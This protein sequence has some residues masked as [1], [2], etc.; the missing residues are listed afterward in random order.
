M[1]WHI[2]LIL[3]IV[4]AVL[5][6]I[7]FYKHV[8]FL[9]VG[10]GLAVA[11]IGTALLILYFSSM[12]V[13]SFLQCAVLILY[14]VRLSGFLIY[15]EMKNAVYRSTLKSV[16][17]NDDDMSF[18]A[19][20][21]IWAG[22]SFLYAAETS[23]VLF[24]LANGSQDLIVP[25]IGIC[26][27]LCGLFLETFADHQKTQQKKADPHMA[28]MSGLYRIVRCPN[29]LGEITFW[30]GVML[31]GVTCIQGAVQWIVAVTAYLM[32]FGIMVSGALRLEKRQNSHYMKYP[33]YQ[34]YVAKTP[35]L[36]PWEPFHHENRMVKNEQ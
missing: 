16:M 12:N 1:D 11:G 8:Y 24:R 10:Y 6:S 22:V 31:G 4:S 29:Y 18:M 28:A 35:L 30:T 3:C 20:A 17:K 13:I 9:S 27:A 5:C 33:A 32:I 19:K 15:R 2:F 7:G 14:G 25:V 23:P 26:I 21:G 36:F 34:A